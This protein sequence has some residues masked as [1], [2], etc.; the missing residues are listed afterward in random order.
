MQ[1]KSNQPIP[2]GLFQMAASL[3]TSP[4][5][6]AS[7]P[8]SFR[9]RKNPS[10]AKVATGKSNA[11]R[12]KNIEFRLEAPGAQSVELAADFTDWAKSPV[13]LAMSRDG[14]WQTAV[15]LPPGQYSYR[16]IVDG[17]WWDDPCCTQR[18]ANPFGTTNAVVDVP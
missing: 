10:S 16:F 1:N 13:K 8:K 18:V 2:P 3:E 14:V 12:D 17:Q 9:N 4:S 5:S 7:K 15:S 11:A 6:Q